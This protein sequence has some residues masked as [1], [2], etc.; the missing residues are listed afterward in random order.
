M[1]CNISYTTCVPFIPGEG[2]DLQRYWLMMLVSYSQTSAQQNGNVEQRH[3]RIFIQ[4]TFYNF[5]VIFLS[6]VKMNIF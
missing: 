6:L 3:A 1:Y 5:K 2:N 4:K